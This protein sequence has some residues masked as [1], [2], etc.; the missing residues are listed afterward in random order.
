MDKNLS[1]NGIS[2]YL[3]LDNSLEENL[4]LIAKANE[5]G[6]KR[7][8]TSLHI[9]ETNVDLLK[10][11]MHIVLQRAKDLDM[12]IISDIS[13]NT[14]SLLNLDSL[15]TAK[16]YDWGISTIRLDFG[17]SCEEI[18][19]L[20]KSKLKLQFNAS[21]ITRDFLVE[22]EHFNTDFTHI[23]ALHNFYPREGTGLSVAKLV[24]Q[25]KL[26]HEFKIKVA[27]FVPSYNKPRSPLKRGLPTLEI[28]RYKSATLAMNHL[29]QLGIDSVFIGDSL[30]T[31]AELETL[32]KLNGACLTIRAK[33]L[34]QDDSVKE[35]ITKNIFNARLDEAENAIRTQNSRA[36]FKS[37]NIWREFIA[38]RGI[39]TITLD[40]NNSLRYKGEL[41]IILKEQISDINVNVIG[42]IYEEDLILLDNLRAGSD[43]KIEFS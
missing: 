13:P 21:T 31:V 11:Q 12:E 26:L 17:Y 37:V 16:L 36:I 15:D 8:F 39:G 19:K 41:Q 23:D 29:M 38:K 4:N 10:E 3:G 24:E 25:N 42:K 2:I 35:A 43:F 7:I 1:N 22:L 40:N 6:I 33:C 14:L 20:S 9:P 30:P 34:T 5:L 18:A 32:S 27:G 28:H